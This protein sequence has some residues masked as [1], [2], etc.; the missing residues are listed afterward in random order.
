MSDSDP[1][2]DKLDVKQLLGKC[3]NKLIKKKLQESYVTLKRNFIKKY[4]KLSAVEKN[5]SIKNLSLRESYA[6]PLNTTFNTT[7]TSNRPIPK[8]NIRK[9]ENPHVTTTN[10]TTTQKPIKTIRFH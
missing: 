3:Q 5:Q 6:L 7:A 2:G 10:T 9:S 8:L 1:E 4:K